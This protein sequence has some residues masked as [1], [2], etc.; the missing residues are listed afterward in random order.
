MSLEMVHD[1]TLAIECPDIVF[2]EGFA[3]NI[4]ALIGILD[5]HYRAI[6]SVHALNHC[7]SYPKKRAT[8]DWTD[9]L[10]S[11]L[12]VRKILLNSIIL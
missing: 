4:P 8:A 6:R 11:P 10:S 1:E 5:R 3:L 2:R 7:A 9:H 12:K